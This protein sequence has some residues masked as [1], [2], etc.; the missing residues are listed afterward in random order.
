MLKKITVLFF[1]VYGISLFA[2]DKLVANPKRAIKN[3]TWKPAKVAGRD[4]WQLL[5]SSLDKVMPELADMDFF[6]NGGRY[7]R[8]SFSKRTGGKALITKENIITRTLA[9]REIK[10]LTPDGKNLSPEAKFSAK[11]TEEGTVFRN[12]GALNDNDDWTTFVAKGFR[13]NARIK[14]K[15]LKITLQAKFGKPHTIAKLVIEHGA[16]KDAGRIRNITLQTMES[17][18]L[19]KVPCKIKEITTRKLEITPDKPVRTAEFNLAI[20][21]W[22][23]LLKLNPELLQE[24]DYLKTHPFYLQAFIRANRGD[25]FSLTPENFDTASFE[26]FIKEYK[27]THLG[28]YMPEWDSNITGMLGKPYTA[29]YMPDYMKNYKTREEGRKAFEKFFKMQQKLQ[30]NEIFPHSGNISTV[31]YAP[32]WGVKTIGL[33]LSGMNSNLPVRSMMMA[34]RGGARQFGNIPWKHYQAFFSSYGHPN[35]NQPDNGK[36]HSQVRRE[37]FTGYYMGTNFHQPEGARNALLKNT[38]D[39][40]T[41][42]VKLSPNGKNY[43]ELYLWSKNPE[44]A[45]GESYTPILFLVDYNHG[46]NGRHGWGGNLQFKCWH[47]IL[48]KDGDY[49][50]E[51]FLRTVDK[52]IDSGGG[53]TQ[54]QTPPYSPNIRNS[55]IGDICDLFFANPP[56]YNGSIKPEHLKKYPVVV[57]LGEIKYNPT[58]IENLKDY[59]KNGGTLVINAAQC[60]GAMNDPKFLGLKVIDGKRLRDLVRW[61]ELSPQTARMSS[62]RELYNIVPVKLDGAKV[63]K[64][65]PRAKVPLLTKFNYGKGNVLVTTPYYMLLQKKQIA[66][67]MIEELLVDLQRELLPVQISGDVQF[68][69]NKI[70]PDHWKIVLINNKGIMKHPLSREVPVSNYAADVTLTAPT[71]TKLK[72]VLGKSPI[73]VKDYKDRTV[74]SL[75]IQPGKISVI[76]AVIPGNGK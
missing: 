28:F 29:R 46:H 38:T 45:R 43:R 11:T 31:Q 76:D 15:P 42:V 18:K 6:K 73:S 4:Y 74:A 19:R 22:P 8:G 75:K 67:P 47:T 49:M 58:L 36:A 51:N 10:I 64:T 40:G 25:I 30:F 3:N 14:F 32:A 39:N 44:G 23:F 63:L 61:T 35:M 33:Q 48:F 66:H 20:N 12:T 72:K 71:R 7:I 34:M 24:A 13:G 16:F 41:K 54:V 69:L 1:L 68:L 70:S 65:A 53:I 26:K 21:G 50:H 62:K 37:L 52:F 27:N 56:Q 60:T 55:K 59:V 17:G 57:L 2:G 5:N 9:L